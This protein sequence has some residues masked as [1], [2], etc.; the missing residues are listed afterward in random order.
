MPLPRISIFTDFPNKVEKDLLKQIC[1]GRGRK[2]IHVSQFPRF[3]FSGAKL[4]LV[5]FDKNPQGV[6]FLAKV[7]EIADI[8]Q[9]FQAVD[10]IR[11]LVADCSLEE[12]KP[13]TS[14]RLGALL[15]RH[16]GTDQPAGAEQPVSF[17]EVLYCPESRFSR[18]DLEST[19]EDVYTKLYNA[20][21]TCSKEEVSLR[22][23]YKRYFR[24]DIVRSKIAAI[25]GSCQ[26]QETF[27]FLSTEIYNPLKL[28]D[29]LPTSVSTHVGR[30]HGDLHPD[31]I[32]LDRT[33]RP[34]LIDFAWAKAPR[35]VLLDFVL[36]ENSIRFKDFP[37]SA[38][39]D[40]QLVIDRMLL[41]E[42]GWQSINEDLFSDDETARIYVR[43]ALMVGKIRQKAREILGSKFSIERYLLSQF[44]VLY[45]LMRFDTYEQYS[46]TRALGLISKRL[47]ES[48][49][50]SSFTGVAI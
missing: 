48:G 16:R 17:R 22:D 21:T 10:S 39:L 50:A 49:L 41:E 9:E 6:P 11:D 38:N 23:H 27:E 46:G 28:R 40:E 1:R 34:N 36:L 15:Y 29:E 32:I 37:R 35:D 43:L 20:H 4:L 24:G 14:G 12:N 3:G 18:Q 45:G 30:V 26:G 8:Q 7:A 13:F 44:I 47:R 33:N 25:L 2:T 5:Y 31:N 42:G 19:L